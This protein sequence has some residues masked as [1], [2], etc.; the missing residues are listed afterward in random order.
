M[1]YQTNFFWIS[2]ANMTKLAKKYR[3][4][5][6]LQTLQKSPSQRFAFHWLQ[7]HIE[8]ISEEAMC[9]LNAGNKLL[10]STF[11]YRIDF[12]KEQPEIQINNWDA[13]WWQ[14]KE[15]WKSV[16]KSNFKEL[17]KLRKFLETSIR[18]RSNELG[19]FRRD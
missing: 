16:D 2:V 13:G 8:E 11:K 4:E 6:T 18:A 14:L 15:L 9:L 12:D 17:I 10:R 7:E 1:I 3:N 5:K 19:W